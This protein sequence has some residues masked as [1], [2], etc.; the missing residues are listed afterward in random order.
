MLKTLL[1]IIISVLFVVF[2]LSLAQVVTTV[3]PVA[4]VVL[5][6]V[7]MVTTKPKAKR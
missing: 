1:D 5:A 3:N 4:V 6:L 2:A 7:L